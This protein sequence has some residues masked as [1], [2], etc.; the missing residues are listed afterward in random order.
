MKNITSLNQLARV[1][2][3]SVILWT[4][5]LSL[6]TVLLPHTAWAFDRF[7]P[8]NGLRVMGTSATAWL[9]AIAFEATIAVLTHRLA[10]HIESTPRYTSGNVKWRQFQY[11]YLNAYAMGLLITVGVSALANLAHAVQFGGGLAIAPN[12]SFIYA[13]YLAAF[14]AILPF[15][16]LLFA[17]VLSRA[18]DELQTDSPELQD[19]KTRLRQAGRELQASKDEQKKLQEEVNRLTGELQRLKALPL[20]PQEVG[21]YGRDL[22]AIIAGTETAAAVAERYGTS[23]ATVSRHK[24]K[25]NGA[26]HEVRK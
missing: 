26:V 2:V 16:S 12:D 13:I 21:E 24:A 18:V 20:I 25:L 19:M 4:V 5:Y 15:A 9:A 1:N 10:T 6:L 23:E 3:T 17:R 22:L 8:D 11:R 14:G 7:E